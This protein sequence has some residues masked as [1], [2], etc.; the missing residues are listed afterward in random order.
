MK[1]A[2]IFSML[3]LVSS[4]QMPQPASGQAAVLTAPD[5]D[6]RQ[7]LQQHIQTM[8]GFSHVLLSAN[9]LV[10]SSEL[11]IERRQQAIPQGDLLQGRDL[12]MP[13]RFRLLARDG[14]CWLVH[15]NSGEQRLLARAKCHVQ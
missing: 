8:S 5:A 1:T 13:H 4:C 14:Q 3:L 11:V 9:D 6:A 7:E 10:Q 12:E 2:S 15:L